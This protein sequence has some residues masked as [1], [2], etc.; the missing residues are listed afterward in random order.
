M[1]SCTLT[2][3]E[4][5][6][7]LPA[8]STAVHSTVVSPSLNVLPEGGMHCALIFLLV[9]SVASTLKFTIDPGGPEASAITGL[10]GKVIV[11]GV[12]SANCVCETCANETCGDVKAKAKAIS[13]NA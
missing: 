10:T 3:N 5:L 8:P 2:V 7:S 9:S 11:G 1:V 13:I 12:L 6:F 4:S